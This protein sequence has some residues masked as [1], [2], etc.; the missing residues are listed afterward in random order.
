M[1]SVRRYRA[2]A[3]RGLRMLRRQYRGAL[4][5]GGAVYQEWL[6]DNHYLLEREGKAAL[7]ELRR[8]KARP[9]DFFQALR[10][11]RD[12]C[13]GGNMPDGETLAQALLR[14]K[15]TSAGAAVVPL[16]LRLALMEGAVRSIREKDPALRLK[17]LSGAVTGLRALP[18]MDFAALL[19]QVSPLERRLRRD[20]AGVY[21]RMEESSRAMYRYLLAKRAKRNR[22]CEEEEARALLGR[23]MGA[24]GPERHVGASLLARAYH[25]RRGAALLACESLL[26]VLLAGG[27]ALALNAWLLLPLLCLPLTA[28]GRALLEAAFLRGAQPLPLPRME[29]GG[30]VPEEGRTLITVSALLPC[31]DL[32]R[33][34]EELHSSNGGPNV[35]ICMLA[36]LKGANE[37]E[38][39]EDEIVLNAARAETE[40]LCAKHGGGFLLA[41]RHR[42]FSPTMGN[43]AGRERKR[44]AICDLVGAIHGGE[45]GPFRL[46]CGDLTHLRDYK[47]L[48]ALDA[49]T[50]L[51]LDTVPEMVSAALHPCNR[52]RFDLALGRV[53]RGYGILAP[54]VELDL[55]SVRQSAFAHAMAGEGGSSPYANRVSERYQDLFGHG[56]FAGKGLIDVEAFAAL[57]KA[58]PFPSEQVLSHDIL[59]GGYLRTG[60]LADVHVSD[61]FPARQ[62]SYFTRQERWVRGDWQ[63]LPFLR[64]KRGLPLLSRYQLFDNLRRSLVAPGCLAAILASL[65]VPKEIAWVLALAGIAGVCG[66]QVI[67]ALRCLCSGGVAML[68]RDYYAGGL[69]AALGDLTRGALQ[70]V[71][72]AQEAWTNTCAAV[73][74]IWRGLITRKK[75]LEWTTAAQGEQAKKLWRTMLSLWPSLLAGGALLALGGAGQRLISIALLAD[76]LFAPLSGRKIRKDTPK[77]SEEDAARIQDY[78]KAMWSYFETWCTADQ[79]WL[80]PDNVQEAPVFRVAARTSPT[81]LGLYLLCI[82]AARDLDLIDTQ[83]MAERL[84]RTLSSIERLERWHGNLLNWYD[85]RTLCPL[86]PRYVSTVDTGN[87]LVAVR[88]LRRGLE[89]YAGEAVGAAFLPPAG[90]DNHSGGKNA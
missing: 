22:R 38:T 4:G 46:L 5:K 79:H 36:D 89:E 80:P 68:A 8:L 6:R 50:R 58:R 3:A 24:S 40:R 20:P 69:P 85:T 26:P 56:I 72:L 44:G 14:D 15:C 16:A 12:L 34:M 9:A 65:F 23:A 62:G 87:F 1:R 2:R 71:V 49:D 48:L 32:G 57:E 60:F 76:L 66:G 41:V 70:A 86:E 30:A 42:T 10:I 28:L 33:R 53:V 25:P 43:Y 73:R 55:D 63:N 17:L 45:T 21:P 47:Y 39:P 13:S 81:N 78:C 51:P 74:G 88:T 37:A 35:D 18:D 52:P 84:E 75:R 19:E 61:G 83:G 54:H 90:Q 11:C 31:A 27:I 82:L 29:L 7:R 64:K 59:E 77:L 67:N